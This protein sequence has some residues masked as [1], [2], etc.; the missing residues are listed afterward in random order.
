MKGEYSI[1]VALL[2]GVVE[3][4]NY[5]INDLIGAGFL[6]E[7]IEAIRMLIYSKDSLY[8][9]YIKEIK[10]NMLAAIVK[11]EDLKH[12]SDLTRLNQ[13]TIRG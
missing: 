13:I 7:V 8:F 9:D 10:N 1:C 2:H 5:T 3:D 6:L 12:N 11:I 4:S